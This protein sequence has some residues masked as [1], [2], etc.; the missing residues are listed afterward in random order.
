MSFLIDFN[1]INL[2]FSPKKIIKNAKP[3]VMTK[4]AF[5]DIFIGMVPLDDTPILIEGQP[6]LPLR[7]FSELFGGEVQ[8]DKTTT[9]AALNVTVDQISELWES[10][11]QNEPDDSKKG[12]E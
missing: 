11:L 12:K 6:Y 7:S 9:S 1:I 8:W 3:E 2:F 4:D 10:K 5:K